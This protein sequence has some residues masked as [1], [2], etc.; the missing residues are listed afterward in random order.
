MQIEGCVFEQIGVNQYGVL[1]KVIGSS[2]PN[3]ITDGTYYILN[4][5]SVLVTTGKYKYV[6]WLTLISEI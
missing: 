4:E 3:K 2:L 1:F 5:D 6:L